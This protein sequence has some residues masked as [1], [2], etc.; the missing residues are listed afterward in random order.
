MDAV[1]ASFDHARVVPPVAAANGNAEVGFLRTRL[2]LLEDLL[3]QHRELLGSGLG[4]R[5]LRLKVGEN[6]G[7][8][9]FAHP[10]VIVYVDIGVVQA[11]LRLLRGD[12]GNSHVLER[13]A[14]R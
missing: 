6:L 14:R 11:L 7:A 2:D 9:L 1:L 3:L 8:F 12:R 10:L 5:I 4:V 13:T